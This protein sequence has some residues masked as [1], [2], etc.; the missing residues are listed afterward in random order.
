[1]T[2]YRLFDINRASRDFSTQFFD[3]HGFTAGDWVITLVGTTPTNAIQSAIGGKLLQTMAGT[4][5]SQDTLQYA[6]GTAAVLTQYGF[7]AGKKLQ[8]TT[9]VQISH[10]VQQDL[11]AGLSS[12]ST[13]PIGTPPTNGIFFRKDDESARLYFVARKAGVETKLDTQIDMVA[14]TD[15]DMEFYYD[16]SH[17]TIAAYVNQQKVGSLPVSALPTALLALTFGTQNGDAN[18]RTA[19]WDFI[20]AQQQR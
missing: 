13:D 12:V 8:F 17:Q 3:F 9:R 2:T 4:D 1:M 6:G 16:G 14:A 18:S 19:L 7:V 11:I 5:N 15:Y 20:G 10:A